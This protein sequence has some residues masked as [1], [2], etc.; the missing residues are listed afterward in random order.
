MAKGQDLSRHQQKIVRRYYEHLDTLTLEKLAESVSEL[1]L[2]TDAKAAAK[3][4]KRVETALAKTAAN[5]ARVR[6]VLEER[7]VKGLAQL[8]N[9][10]AGGQGGGRAGGR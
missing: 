2:A 8:V 7:D 6:K 3:L 9:D 10:L 5:D 4:W 1:Y